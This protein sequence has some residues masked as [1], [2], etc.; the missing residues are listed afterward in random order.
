MKAGVGGKMGGLDNKV[1]LITGAGSG[2]GRE[3]SIRF[4][5]EG[6]SLVICDINTETIEETKQLIKS[7]YPNT[8]L[9]I[10]TTDISQEDQIKNLVELTFENFEVL[11]VLINNAAIGGPQANLLKVKNEE[12]DQVMNVN[13]KGTW[14][15]CKYFGFKMR[16]QKH[17]KPVRGKIINIGSTASKVG[18]PMIGTYS[19]SKF[20][21]LGLTQSLAKDLAP[22]ITVNAICPGMV[23]TP[24]Y[25]MNE[26][27]MQ[28][29]IDHYKQYIWLKRWGNVSDIA[30]AA[31]FLASDDSNFMTGQSINVNG[32]LLMQ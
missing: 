28:T 19:I 12:W 22:H 4:A 16:K 32:G 25:K 9:V 10:S 14:M 20:G 27:L 18:Y 8:K 15:M 21:V 2:I 23:K 13:L 29:A 3:I 5:K 26:E 17:L 31:Y 24:V 1:C 30:G 11:N 7:D 6:A